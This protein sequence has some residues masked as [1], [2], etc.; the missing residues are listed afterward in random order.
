VYRSV[1][2]FVG[3]VLRQHVMVRI[4]GGWNTLDNYLARCDPCRSQRNAAVVSPTTT[5]SVVGQWPN[6]GESERAVG[7]RW[8]RR[9]PADDRLDASSC[10]DLTPPPP[11]SS[12]VTRPPW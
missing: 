2:L 11:P 7:E 10:T 5:G 3:Q 1:G 9:S 6:P 4:G 8:R 12:Q